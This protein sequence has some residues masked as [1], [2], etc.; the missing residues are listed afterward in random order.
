MNIKKQST[1][2]TC[3]PI[4][5]MA[6][7]KDKNIK[8]NNNEEINILIEGLKFTDLDYSTGQVVYTCKKYK[9]VAEQYIDNIFYYK[10]LS[11]LK[12]PNNMKLINKK[13]DRNFLIEMINISPI[14]IYVD[15][16]YL[17]RISTYPHL[18]PH[19][20]HFII[21]TKFNKRSCRYL[22]PIT[23]KEE[24]M[25]TELL[26]RSIQSLRNKMKICPKVIIIK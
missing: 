11:K 13:I 16:Y 12:Y 22:D 9:I 17:G 19:Y 8:V 24:K 10:I 7:L 5:L 6:L 18:K 1:C 25:K 14:I 26:I 4:C 21:L 15:N 3:L 23:G 20:P 2:E